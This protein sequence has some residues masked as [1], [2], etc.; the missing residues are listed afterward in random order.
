MLD[1][2]PFGLSGKRLYASLFDNERFTCLPGHDYDTVIPQTREWVCRIPE[3]MEAEVVQ[4]REQL[5]SPIC[6]LHPHHLAA[7]RAVAVLACTASA[8]K[9]STFARF[10][11]INSQAQSRGELCDFQIVTAVSVT[12]ISVRG[13]PFPC[14]LRHL[15][16]R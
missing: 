14:L 15:A 3:C 4:G 8:Q 12:S 1:N 7:A 9:T 13:Q 10:C 16:L 5:R 6:S 11:R 2:Q